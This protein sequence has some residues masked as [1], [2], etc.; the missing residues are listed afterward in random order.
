MP[1]HFKDILGVRCKRLCQPIV[2]R[3]RELEKLQ[4]EVLLSIETV[5]GASGMKNEGAVGADVAKEAS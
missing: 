5:E 3:S 4:N 1:R 2:G